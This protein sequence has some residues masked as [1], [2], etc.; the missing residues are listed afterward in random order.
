MPHLN[1]M[2]GLAVILVLG[3]LVADELDDLE[4]KRADRKVIHPGG[5][6]LLSKVPEAS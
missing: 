4:K 6:R 1:P 5:I 3:Q 2:P